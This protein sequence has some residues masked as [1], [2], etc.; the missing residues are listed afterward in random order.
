[1]AP[2]PD[3]DELTSRDLGMR[4]SPGGFPAPPLAEE[5]S[6]ISSSVN[7]GINNDGDYDLAELEQLFREAERRIQASESKSQETEVPSPPRSPQSPRPPKQTNSRTTDARRNSRRKPAKLKLAYRHLAPMVQEYR[8]N[9]EEGGC[10]VKT[11]KPLAVGRKCII[12]VKAPGLSEPLEIPG[13]VTWSSSKPDAEGNGPGM[14]IRYQ[15][16]DRQRDRLLA[17]LDRHG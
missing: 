4:L 2:R 8:D 17:I 13:V 10:F 6:D 1:M 3:E 11:P 14:R 9:L 15:L 7:S 5:L 16:D 12:N